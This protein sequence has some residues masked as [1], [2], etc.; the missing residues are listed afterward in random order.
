VWPDVYIYEELVEDM[1]KAAERVFDA[2]AK[3]QL[4]MKEMNDA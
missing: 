1:A 2:N 4:F 3:G